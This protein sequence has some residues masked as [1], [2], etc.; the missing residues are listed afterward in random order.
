MKEIPEET[1]TKRSVDDGCPA[2]DEKSS[3]VSNIVEES[4]KIYN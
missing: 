2:I 1:D 3:G 4:K